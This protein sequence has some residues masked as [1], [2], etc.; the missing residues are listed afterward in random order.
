MILS[1]KIIIGRINQS[2]AL[3][4]SETGI[5]RITSE[6]KNPNDKRRIENRINR[7]FLF[8]LKDCFPAKRYRIFQELSIQPKNDTSYEN[9]EDARPD[10]TIIQLVDDISS[11]GG[12]DF[13]IECK[14]LGSSTS[15]SWE[16]NKKYV[17]NGI[18]RFISD[19][20][21]YGIDSPS[22]AMVGYIE[23]MEFDDILTQVNQA[24]DQQ[25]KIDNLAKTMDWQEKSTTHLNHS[26]ERSFE[27]SPFKLHHLWID[28]RDCYPRS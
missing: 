4:C 14:R 25:L 7:A 26:F 23:D 1:R 22:G 15:P 13:H 6:F 3:L 21:H 16:Y 20:F 10:L 27:K 24:I 9:S 17:E 28:L 11:D 8:C 12:L 5:E 19:S 2:L 18:R